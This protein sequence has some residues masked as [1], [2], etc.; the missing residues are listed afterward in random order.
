MKRAVIFLLFLAGTAVAAFAWEYYR[1]DLPSGSKEAA[2]R[3]A[4]A[5]EL[6]GQPE[7]AIEGGRIDVLTEDLAI[8]VDWQHKWHEGLGQALHYADATGREGA[9]ALITY[10]L[11]PDRLQERSLHRL[12]MVERLYRKSNIRLIVL[13]PGKPR[14]DKGLRSDFT[15]TG[16]TNAPCWLNS[17]TGVRHNP[18]C[19]FYEN[20]GEGYH[21]GAN[22]GKACSVCGG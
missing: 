9:V 7:V 6:G 5:S 16:R 19:R 21:C 2:W 13:F 17:Q 8:E 3:D 14:E 20:T 12:D 4:L 11:G 22:E 1:F 18:G 10:G 15:R